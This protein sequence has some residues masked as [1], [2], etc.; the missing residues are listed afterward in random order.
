RRYEGTGLGL[1]LVKK[2]VELHGGTVS[3]DSQPGKGSCFTIALPW[4]PGRES[5][6]LTPAKLLDR[7]ARL[8]NTPRGSKRPLILLAEDNPDNIQTLLNYLQA[9][10]FDLE[11]AKNGIEAVQKAISLHPDLILMD[12]SMPEMDGLEAMRQIRA[13]SQQANLPIIALTA[14]AMAGDREQ[15]LAAGANE[16]LP[17]PVQIRQLVQLIQSFLLE[18]QRKNDEK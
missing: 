2:L 1:V 5:P 4:N 16:Y 8:G 17:K 13:N 11:V 3:L 12:I 10:G 9:K 7:S 6:R 14:F 15:C 18:N